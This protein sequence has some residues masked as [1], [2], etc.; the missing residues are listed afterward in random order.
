MR[1]LGKW[2]MEILSGYYLYMAPI[3][4]ANAYTAQ[5]VMLSNWEYAESEMTHICKQ[6]TILGSLHDQAVLL[7]V[8]Y[9]E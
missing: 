3:L 5:I 9:K 1:I 2:N 6:F 4:H 7:A 8:Y